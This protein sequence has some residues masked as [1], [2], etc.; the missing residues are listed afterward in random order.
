[1]SPCTKYVKIEW[2]KRAHYVADDKNWQENSRAKYI[3]K[4]AYV[5]LPF[6]MIICTSH[7]PHGR[8]YIC[9]GVRRHVLDS[10]VENHVAQK[11]HNSRGCKQLHLYFAVLSPIAAGPYSCFMYNFRVILLLVAVIIPLRHA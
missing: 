8:M 10:S 4:V 5:V 6:Y 11:M 7:N 9:Q 3:S 2:Q 1:M